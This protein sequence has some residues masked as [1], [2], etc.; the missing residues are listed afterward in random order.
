[1][2]PSAESDAGRR[3]L[4][5]KK[6]N[7][8]LREIFR[9]LSVLPLEDTIKILD[10]IRAEEDPIAVVR[11]ARAT[12]LSISAGVAPNAV[13]AGAMRSNPRLQAIDLRALT[14]SPIK[15]SA[16]PW[17]TVAS[18]GLVSDLV[19]SFFRWD[20]TFLFP[21]IDRDA[22]IMDMRGCDIENA[23]YCSPLLVNAIC[24]SRCVG[25]TTR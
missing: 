1:M 9:C 15:L 7:T 23:S 20:N 14:N 12:E 16:C 4:D 21:F 24:A 11:L 2:Y 19:A 10:R 25:S 17:T 18:D 22:F 8:Q 5:L 13:L 6:E 3:Q